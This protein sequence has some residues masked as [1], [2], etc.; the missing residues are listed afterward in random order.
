MLPFLLI[1]PLSPSVISHMFVF[2][3]FSVSAVLILFPLLSS[4]LF[5]QVPCCYA[6][7]RQCDVSGPSSS[8]QNF[9]MAVSKRKKR[10]CA[11]GTFC[12]LV[13]GEIWCKNVPVCSRGVQ[14]L[15]TFV[16]L[17]LD[18]CGNFTLFHMQQAILAGQESHINET[19]SVK[20][21]LLLLLYL[22]FLLLFYFS[23]YLLF[24][25]VVYFSLTSAC[26]T[27]CVMRGT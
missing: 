15:N 11:V 17:F 7:S 21:T 1:P 13:K 18:S 19:Q 12:Y 16:F 4:I 10:F 26:C 27:L 14:S 8:Q 3:Q 6:V 5:D 24:M 20:I 22:F 23:L 2:H 9:T 25:A